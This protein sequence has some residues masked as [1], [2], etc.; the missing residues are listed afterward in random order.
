VQPKG[1]NGHWSE[2]NRFQ[3]QYKAYCALGRNKF[4][5]SLSYVIDNV[6]D[7]T[8]KPTKDKGK[9]RYLSATFKKDSFL[10]FQ[11][12]KTLV[13][14]AGYQYIC[15]YENSNDGCNA[16]RALQAHYNGVLT[17]KAT[18][19]HTLMMV[20]TLCYDGK[21]N[22]TPWE[23]FTYKFQTA[24]NDLNQV[25]TTYQANGTPVQVMGD[26]WIVNKFL[27]AIEDPSLRFYTN[28]GWMKRRQMTLE[29][30]IDYM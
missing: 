23:V 1:F 4:G 9:S 21:A 13:F 7:T 30:A 26:Q 19:D 17:R 27:D 22:S 2:W 18:V 20:E 16:W 15:K 5:E 3:K 25:G 28:S 14:G 29:E 8:S 6:L 24:W 12:L 11:E 10:V